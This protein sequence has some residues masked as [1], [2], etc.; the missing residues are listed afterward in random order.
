MA[1]RKRGLGLRLRRRGSLDGHVPVS[2]RTRL[3]HFAAHGGTAEENVAAFVRQARD[4]PCWLGHVDFDENCWDVTASIAQRLGRPQELYGQ[5]LWFCRIGKTRAPIVPLPSCINNFCKAMVRQT[6]GVRFHVLRSRIEACQYLGDVLEAERCGSISECSIAV[7]DAA[8]DLARRR[9]GQGRAH[10]VACQ[11]RLIAWFLDEHRMTLAPV[12]DWSPAKHGSVLP[13]DSDAKAAR[14]RNCLPTDGY[15]VALG[16][17]FRVA[18]LDTDLIVTSVLALQCCGLGWRIDDVLNLSEDCNEGLDVAG[19]LA[20]RCIG[21][22][23]VGHVVRNIPTAMTALAQLALARIRRLTEPARAA[24][25]WYDERSTELYL[26]GNLAHFRTKP[27]LTTGEAGVLI[28]LPPQQALCYVRRNGIEVRPAES[29]KGWQSFEVS[30]AGLQRHYLDQLPKRSWAAGGRNHH[31]LLLVQQGLFKRTNSQTGSPCMFQVVTYQNI[32]WA[33]MPTGA[34][35]SMFRRL[36]TDCGERGRDRTHAIRHFFATLALA[37]R[38]SGDDLAHVQGRTDVRHNAHYEHFLDEAGQALL[39]RVAADLALVGA[40]PDVTLP[41]RDLL[42]DPA[43][44][45]ATAAALMR[46]Q[47]LPRARGEDSVD[48][49]RVA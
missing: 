34:A 6:R 46:A 18:V 37:R 23:R 13:A 30:F 32:R 7:L 33:L 5:R 29:L 22:K 38:V 25:R 2:G 27:W 42:P 35:P 48:T 41:P 26:P 14:A 8:V 10:S 24:K 49:L 16:E 36:G 15:I 47:K 17:A 40:S 3:P 11:I 44:L 21:S 1:G 43:G 9:L 45:D 31:P 28:G 20:L 19:A 12:G 4:N 39:A